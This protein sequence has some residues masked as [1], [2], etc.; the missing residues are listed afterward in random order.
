MGV[1]ADGASAATLTVTLRDSLNAPVVGHTVTLAQT[2]SS[3]LSA[4][5]GPSDS[6]GQVT[7]TVTN[8]T[9]E[10]VTYTAT[11]VTDGVTIT[12]TT[13]GNFTAL[14]GGTVILEVRVAASSDDAEEGVA[15]S[16]DLTSSDLELVVED[17]IQ[18]VGM[19]FTGVTIPQGATIAD[20]YVQFQVDETSSGTSALTIEGEAADNALTF[21]ATPSNIS[22]R[23]RTAAGVA[24]APTPWQTVGETGSNQRTPPLTAVIQE[25][26]NRSGWTSNNALVLLLTGTGTRIAESFNGVPGAAPLTSCG[27]SYQPTDRGCGHLDGDRHPEWGAGRWRECGHAHRHLAR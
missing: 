19:R 20:A 7:F 18:Q 23:S 11:D 4:A 21:S 1:P 24:W 25:I 6:T 8:T 17:V 16:M 15:N 22:L 27:V 14:P 13:A 9:V 3:T 2:G 10:S 5:S 12:Q 26:V